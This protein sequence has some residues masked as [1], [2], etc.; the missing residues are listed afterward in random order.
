LQKFLKTTRKNIVDRIDGSS[1][2]MQGM[3]KI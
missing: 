1:N 3:N 2:R